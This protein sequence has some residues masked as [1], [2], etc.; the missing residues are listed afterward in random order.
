M[1]T[2]LLLQRGERELPRSLLHH[3][4][5]TRLLPLTLHC[6]CSWSD[7]QAH[8]LCRADAC[9]VRSSVLCSCKQNLICLELMKDIR[10]IM[11]QSVAF[12]RVLFEALS[13]GSYCFLWGERGWEKENVGATAAKAWAV[14]AAMIFVFLFVLKTMSTRR[15]LWVFLHF[16]YFLWSPLI[17][18]D[19]VKGTKF[20]SIKRDWRE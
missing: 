13:W 4:K 14:S 18:S 8:E 9:T 2:T 19:L 12:G 7:A 16:Y 11:V 17:D 20:E 3:D 6:T 1:D 15:Y 5:A 10:G